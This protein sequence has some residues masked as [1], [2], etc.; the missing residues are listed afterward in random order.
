MDAAWAVTA[1]NAG[2]EV[3]AELRAMLDK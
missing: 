1:A 2:D 3:A